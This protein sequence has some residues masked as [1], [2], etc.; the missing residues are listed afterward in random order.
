MA[1]TT[2]EAFEL[3]SRTGQPCAVCHAFAVVEADVAVVEADTLRV[4][5][6][7]TSSHCTACQAEDVYR[8]C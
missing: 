1:A 3:D 5:T 4:L 7:V 8:T 6:H 2:Y